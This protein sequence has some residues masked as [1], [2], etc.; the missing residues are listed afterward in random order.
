[1]TDDITVPGQP[2]PRFAIF[3][4]DIDNEPLGLPIARFETAAEA[5]R[6]KRRLDRRYKF[7]IPGRRFV[8]FAELKELMAAGKV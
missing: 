6:F 5:L 7:Q 8:N 2:S 1:M 4:C 3:E